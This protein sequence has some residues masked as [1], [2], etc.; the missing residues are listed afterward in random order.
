MGMLG[1]D[2]EEEL[3]GTFGREKV[4][5]VK[6]QGIE[7]ESSVQFLGVESSSDENVSFLRCCQV[8]SRNPKLKD[9]RLP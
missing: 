5:A 9:V 8:G 4:A 2:K 7:R 1:R 3:L 6:V